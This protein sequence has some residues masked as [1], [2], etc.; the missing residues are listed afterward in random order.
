MVGQPRAYP[1]LS[2][3]ISSS[4]FEVKFASCGPVVHPEPHWQIISNPQPE[5]YHKFLLEGDKLKGFLLVG[6]TGYVGK[7]R[8]LLMTKA[9][10]KPED[11]V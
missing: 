9:S 10:V 5:F 3:V 4:F 7:L 8:Q 1:G 11:L 6:N 2:A